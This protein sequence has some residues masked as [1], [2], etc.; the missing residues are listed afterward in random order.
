MCE[1]CSE[2]S[3]TAEK[4][5]IKDKYR[6]EQ[7]DGNQVQQWREA[8]ARNNISPKGKK[9]AKHE[10]RLRKRIDGKVD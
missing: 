2:A 9:A 10:V 7:L 6:A 4:Q 1:E 5:A 3:T 8:L